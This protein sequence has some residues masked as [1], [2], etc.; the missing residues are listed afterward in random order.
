MVK[1]QAYENKKLSLKVDSTHYIAL[2]FLTEVFIICQVS[3][4]HYY[5]PPPRGPLSLEPPQKC[6]CAVCFI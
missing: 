2:H 3:M 5:D 4:N 1:I 6:K